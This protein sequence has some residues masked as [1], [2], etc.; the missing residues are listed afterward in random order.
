MRHSP[1]R[2]ASLGLL[3]ASLSCRGCIP[4]YGIANMCKQH[5]IRFSVL[6]GWLFFSAIAAHA[7]IFSSDSSKIQFAPNKVPSGV[8]WSS[9]VSLTDGGLLSEKLPPDRSAEVWV[10]SQPIPAG[11]SWRPPT[12]ATIRLDVEAGA[13]EFTYLG[14]YFRYSCDRVHWSTWYDLPSSKDQK[15]VAGRAF[16]GRL[17]LPRMVNEAYETK[18]REWWKTNPAW[19]SDEHEL[20]VWIAKSDPDF[21]AREFPFIGYVQVRIEGES[22]GVRLRSLTVKVSSGVSG[23]TAP[24]DGRARSTAGDKWFFDASKIRR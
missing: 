7:Q 4:A 10:Q 8:T 19:S 20:C 9:S 12:S 17:S 24:S 14:A 22:R 3:I 1:H 11:M 6:L 15:D 2:A 21:F 18:M 5:K 23:L 13:Q 16:E